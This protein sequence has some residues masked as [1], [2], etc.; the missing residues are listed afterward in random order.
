MTHEELEDAV[1]L[2]AIG[3]LERS[4]RHGESLAAYT[5]ALT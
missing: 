1:P 5:R 2:Y 4:E 3:A